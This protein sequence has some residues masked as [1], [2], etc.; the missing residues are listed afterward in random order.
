MNNKGSIPIRSRQ[1]GFT[2]IE[3]LIS[4]IIVAM[5]V[6]I[7]YS[8]FTSVLASTETANTASE[9]LYTQSFI[10]RNLDGH[11]AQA[12][13]GWQP[14]AVFRPFTDVSAPV[15]RVMVESL[16]SFEG[17]DN[18]DEDSLSF[19]TS[20]P[21]NGATGLPGYYK[22]VTYSIVDGASVEWPEGSPYVG[23]QGEGPVLLVTE[24]PILSYK[25]IQEGQSIEDRVR[26][27][28]E[29][30]EKLEIAT[31]MWTFPVGAMSIRYHDGEEWID[32]WDMTVEERL[33]WAVEVILYWSP[34]D[35]DRASAVSLDPENQFRMVIPLPGGMGIVNAS[36][37]YGRPLVEVIQ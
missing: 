10:T 30:A 34:W 21:M 2:I 18:G 16:F 25:G 4:M 11:L 29:E 12:T 8:T 6:G 14:G 28:K 15:S 13:P 5:V 1:R 24:V 23:I 20:V 3:L 33:P 17:V 37:E 9:Q 36:P 35:N 32:F 7:V 31:P 22:Q 19:T 26:I 27:F